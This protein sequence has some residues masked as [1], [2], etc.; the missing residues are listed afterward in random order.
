MRDRNEASE[1]RIATSFV[2]NSLTESVSMLYLRAEITHC[3]LNLSMLFTQSY[4]STRSLFSSR[5]SFCFT[6]RA[7][8]TLNAVIR[9]FSGRTCSRS[10]NYF[11][12]WRIV[13][14]LPD[15]AHALISI[16]LDLLSLIILC[17]SSLAVS[18]NGSFLGVFFEADEWAELVRLFCVIEGELA[19][20]F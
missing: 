4:F 6:F 19:S 14:V 15:P 1:F 2:V 5:R 17:C 13:V 20:C 16:W 11:T 3:L 10:S 18:N 12:R 9:I 8:S 7:A